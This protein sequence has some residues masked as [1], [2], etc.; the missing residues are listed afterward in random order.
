MEDLFEVC[1]S[2]SGC[3]IVPILFIEETFSQFNCLFIFVKKKLLGHSCMGQFL[4][5]LLYFI[6]LCVYIF[7]NAILF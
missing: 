2:A 4:D 5:S 3:P 1:F 7:A 6:G